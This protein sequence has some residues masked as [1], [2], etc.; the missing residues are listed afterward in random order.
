M[1]I[2]YTAGT[3]SEST[4]SVTS[5]TVTLPAGLAA[6]DYSIIV[7]A[8]NA[9]NG[10]ITTPAGWTDI[11]PDTN[12]TASTSFAMAIFYRKWVSG[13]SNPSIATTSGRTAAVA[14]KVSGADPTTFIDVQAASV[15]QAG[16]GATTVT[17]PTITPTST[18][19][20]FVW[21]GRSPTNGN[22]LT[23]WGNLSAGVTKT[24]EGS[25]QAAS[26]T[27]AGFC[28]GTA[29]VTANTATGTKTADPNVSTTGA[30]GFS[31]SL[32]AAV[33]TSPGNV[34]AVP[35]TAT[36]AATAPAAG[37]AAG[38]AGVTATATASQPAPGVTA[39]A[40]VAAVRSQAT[41]AAVAPVVTAAATVVA[42]KAT[43]T[44]TAI[45]PASVGVS[46]VTAAPKATATA[47]AVAP[48]VSAGAT[49]A[50]IK[51]T[52]TGSATAPGVTAAA[53]VQAVCATATAAALAPTISTSASGTVQA[54]PATA[55]ATALAPVLH[56]SANVQAVPATAT[57]QAV[58]PAVTA[59]RQAVVAA[60]L[61]Q[62]TAIAFPP[63]WS[64]GATVQA[65]A[66]TGT[67]AALAPTVGAPNSIQAPRMQANAAAYVPTVTAAA[68]VAPVRMTGTAQAQSPAVTAAALVSPPRATGTAQFRAPALAAGAVVAA[69]R[70]LATATAITPTV[71]TIDMADVLL[72][73]APLAARW[74]HAPLADK[75]S[76]IELL[77]RRYQVSVAP[78][79]QQAK[80]LVVELPDRFRAGL[81]IGD[82]MVVEVLV[83]AGAVKYVGGTVTEASGIDI[84]GATF[85]MNLGSATNP[86]VTWFPPDVSAA[87]SNNATRVLKL[88]VSATTPTG[89]S[90]PGNYYCWARIT[91]SP[92]IEPV[93][94]QGPI[95][96]R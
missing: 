24:S 92:E 63:S 84:S 91:A 54:V 93:R 40:T 17:A 55:S 73:P 78:Q 48:A 42:P 11:V 65:P 15:T 81:D 9:T 74:Q 94:L 38:V 36:A 18:D 88:K 79:D 30:W 62:A 75:Y 27:N 20:V 51:A 87:G 68:T 71:L 12:G 26:Q 16:S 58:A 67:A 3:V 6:G 86:G 22:I 32:N 25:A 10:N 56:V 29:T 77:G 31:F 82:T 95:V 39:A 7:I 70:M 37:G 44:A 4:G 85:E 21:G 1:A 90:V 49:V 14:I 2:T 35:M 57:A 96:V 66:A 13:D 45:A 33:T 5:T 23:P 69:P 83:S 60:P 72:V 46:T 50:A 53:T 8:L 52:A 64:G 59:L 76:I 28:I 47:G 61:L 34:T 89:I 43:A 19:A 80:Y 41:A